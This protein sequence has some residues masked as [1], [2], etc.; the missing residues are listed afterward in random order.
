MNRQESD[1]EVNVIC[2]GIG[3]EPYTCR[4]AH[5]EAPGEYCFPPLASLIT[6]A[7][8]LM[9]ALLEH[10][11]SEL[12]GTYAMEDT[13]SMGIVATEEGG[14]IPCP[15]GTHRTGDGQPGILALSWKQVREIALQFEAL[16]PYERDAVPGSIL[17]IEADNFDPKTGEQREIHC[18]AIS[19]KRYVLFLKD[20]RGTPILLREGVNNEDDKWSMHGLGHLLNPTDPESEDRQ[21]TAQVWLGIIRRA[22]GLRTQKLPFE[23]TPAV[24]RITVSSPAVMRPFGGFNNGK[25]YADQIKP[26]NFLLTS[27][28]L[29]LGHPLGADPEH[30]HLIRPYD[31]D[32]RKWLKDA[33]ID[34]YS[35]NLYRVTTDIDYAE[36]NVARVKKYGDVILEYE[37]HPESKC[38]DADG[39][40]C[41]QQTIGLLKRRRVYIEYIKCIGKESNNLE[42]VEEGLIHS[43][44]DVY[45]EYPDPARD[46]WAMVTLPILK[47]MPLPLLI[48]KSGISRRPL[49]KMRAGVTRPHLENQKILK[50]IAR[51]WVQDQI[52][53]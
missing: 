13:D 20:S 42:K 2:H 3:A 7:A 48:A 46:E 14:I 28:V 12:G 9:L 4:V 25:S 39:N 6:G 18:L 44:D 31:T 26:F 1:K 53:R 41:D 45:T 27:F 49:Q 11:V 21:W 30:F 32:P 38:A 35:G 52:E 10:A 37:F 16:N 8:R 33:W 29:P 22:L 17:K 51:A 36:A 50:A 19:A 24:G 5:P 47:R 15:G 34:Q 43:E 40:T 23:N